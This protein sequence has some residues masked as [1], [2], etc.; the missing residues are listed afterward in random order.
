MM[1]PLDDDWTQIVNITGD[2]TWNA[3]NMRRYFERLENCQYLANGTA[4]HGFGGWLSTNRADESIFLA[5]SKVYPM[6]KVGHPA[7]LSSVNILKWPTVFSPAKKQLQAAAMLSGQLISS[8]TDLVSLLRRDMN[9]GSPLYS[10]EQG[11]YNTP[12]NMDEYKRSSPRNFL[13]NTAQA[14]N[15]GAIKGGKID[16]RTNCLATRVIFA[17]NTTRAV[18]VE[19]LDGESL[20]RAD[21]RAQQNGTSGTPGKI[22]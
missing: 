2:D 3:V 13:V 7:C 8:V 12:L 20:Y 10:T 15:S 21:P 16:I 18:G 5:D 19:F 1:Y 9:V 6:L 14:I 17:P 22:C 11:I 4:G